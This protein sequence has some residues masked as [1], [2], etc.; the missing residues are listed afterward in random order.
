MPAIVYLMNFVFVRR[1]EEME[2]GKLRRLQR[3]ECVIVPSVQHEHRDSHMRSEVE[4]VGLRA[5]VTHE[6]K[7]SGY[8]NGRLDSLFY[9]RQMRPFHR[10][11][12]VAKVSHFCAVDIFPRLELVKR[13]TQVFH[14]LN[15]LVTILGRRATKGFEIILP[16]IH[17]LVNREDQRPPAL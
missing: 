1:S 11:H 3:E 5:H 10:T 16:L 2:E 6:L 8:Q 15:R 13:P 12:A 9:R 4:R 7:T 17:A 14:P